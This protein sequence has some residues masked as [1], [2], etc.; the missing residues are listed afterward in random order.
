VALHVVWEIGPLRRPICGNAYLAVFFPPLTIVIIR[1]M[2]APA[3]QRTEVLSSILACKM[4][5]SS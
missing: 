5:L 2:A 3:V 1:M 4:P